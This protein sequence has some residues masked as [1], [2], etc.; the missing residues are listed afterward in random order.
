MFLFSAFDTYVV[1]V[2]GG[3]PQGGHRK[4]KDHTIFCVQQEPSGNTCGFY[5]CINMVTFRAPAELQCKFKCIYFTL[6]SMFM[7]KYVYSSFDNI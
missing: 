7:I 4:L 2:L 1:K 3:V 6:L 5:I